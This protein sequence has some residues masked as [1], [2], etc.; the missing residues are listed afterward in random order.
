M[1]L[2]QKVKVKVAWIES[3]CLLCKFTAG[4]R[5]YPG[6]TKC[7]VSVRLEFGS[8]RISILQARIILIDILISDRC[9]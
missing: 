7:K 5:F 9:I 3:A 8:I 2:D 6:S 4:V 1:I